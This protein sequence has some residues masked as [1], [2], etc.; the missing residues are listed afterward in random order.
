MPRARE[1]ATVTGAS[2]QGTRLEKRGAPDRVE[3]RG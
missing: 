2:E 1:K 3:G